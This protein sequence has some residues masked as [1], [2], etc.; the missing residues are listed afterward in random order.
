MQHARCEHCGGQ[1]PMNDTVKLKG[2]CLCVGC[3]DKQISQLGGVP[4]E[5]IEAE[6]DPTVCV[7][8]GHDNG[9]VPLERLAGLP[10][11][12]RCIHYFRHRPFPNWIRLGAVGLLALVVFALW[13]NGRFF[14]AYWEMRAS[15][16]AFAEADAAR[17]ADLMESAAQRV[18]ETRELDAFA[19]YLRGLALLQAGDSAEAL[20]HLENA[21]GRIP[22]DFPIEDVLLH[23]RMGKCFDEKDYDGFL[24][25]ATDLAERH[26]GEPS[27]VASVASAYACKYVQTGEAEFKEKAMEALGRAR[28]N[29]HKDPE[30]PEYEDRILYRIESRQIISR[31]EFQQRFPNGWHGKEAP[32]R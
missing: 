11:C 5:A 6:A 29:A 8:C 30:F 20:N 19:T 31:E 10:A 13:F 1:F 4:R 12:D 9:A 28:A 17:A 25:H 2:Q 27:A 15:G 22:P 18:P 23:A 7:N 21:R 14:L 26:P 16:R 3:A 24:R 32:P